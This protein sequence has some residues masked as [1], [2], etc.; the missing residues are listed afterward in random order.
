MVC[1]VPSV[2]LVVVMVEV[3]ALHTGYSVTEAFAVYVPPTAYAC[4]PPSDVDHPTCSY[5]A[6]VKIAPFSVRFT[7]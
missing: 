3:V 6:R 2:P 5:P 7:L 1:D 4:A